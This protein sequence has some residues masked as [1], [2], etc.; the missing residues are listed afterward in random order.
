M[1]TLST[2][3]LPRATAGLSALAVLVGGATA[4]AQVTYDVQVPYNLSGLSTALANPY[5]IAVAPDGTVFVADV[6]SA[7]KGRVIMISPSGTVGGNPGGTASL[8]ATVTTL[9][10]T[11]G[12]TSVTLKQPNAVAVDSAGHLYIADISTDKVY[13]VTAPETSPAATQ[14]TYPGAG[15]TALAT[16]SANNLYVADTGNAIYKIAGGV[17]TALSISPAN[18]KPVGLAVD[19]SGNI[20]FADAR[21][22]ALYKYTAAGGTTTYLA[23]PSSGTFHFSAATAGLPIGMGFD[24]AGNL[25]VLDSEAALLWQI[26]SAT[27]TTNYEVPFSSSTTDPGSLAVS[28]IGNLYISDDSATTA[29]AELFYNNN[30]VNLGTINAGT[31]SPLLNANFQ[32]Q[33]KDSPLQQYENVEGDSTGEITI[34]SKSGKCTGVVGICNMRVEANYLAAAPGLRNGVIGFIDSGNNILAVHVIGTS[35]AAS[36]ALYP[37]IQNTLSQAT[38][39]LWQ[40]QA[41]A[42]TGDAQTFFVADQGADFS[43]TPPGYLHPAVYAYTV[44]AG[45][46]A[47]TPAKVGSFTAPTGLALDAFGNLY[48]ADYSGYVS[49]IPPTYNNG[50][51]TWTSSGTRLTFPAGITLNYPTSVAVDIY[52]NLYIADG[53]PLGVYA[54]TSNPGYI[55]KVPGNGGPATKLS[56]VIDGIPVI[57]P[58][59]LTTDSFGN[60]YIADGGDGITYNGS[61]DMVPIATGT[62]TAISFGNFA[63]ING[64][65]AVAFDAANDL[66]VVDSYNQRVLVVP[67]TYAG[68]VPT[69]DTAGIAPLGG[70]PGVSGL[71]STLFNPSSIV[72]WPGQNT[73]S[74]GDIGFQAPTGSSPYP[75]QVLTLQSFT[76][77]VNASSG[78][79]SVTGINVGNTEIKFLL[80]GETGSV[81]NISLSGCGTLFTTVEPGLTSACTSTITDKQGTGQ[82]TFTLNGS[83]AF[84]YS[85]LGNQIVVNAPSNVPPSGTACNGTYSGIFQGN[86]TVSAGQNCTFVNGGVTGN[87]TENGGNLTLTQSQVGGNV[88]I[89]GGT[90]TIGPGST[91][92]GNLQI[93]N[94]P[95]GAGPN[96]VCGTT[97][98]GNLQFQDSG[99]A[100]LIGSTNPASC[101]GNNVGGDLQVQNNTAA[102]TVAGNTVGGNLQDQNNTAPT[103]VFTNRVGNNLQCG[104]DTSITGGGNTAAS[105]QGQC[106]TF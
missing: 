24:P 37:G 91:V 11:V 79:A 3:S 29:V 1:F 5:G 86:I 73:V 59:D 98:N 19:A 50:V 35:L 84:D 100:L 55:I 25:Y 9:V 17:A 102:T 28:N 20:I 12:G 42:V 56:Y 78:S 6:E 93:Q 2:R 81:A 51:T 49:K 63:P 74:V 4:S 85:A 45:L 38:T 101:A 87:V 43:A 75:T 58:E 10:P 88:Q 66:Y 53:G 41:L 13:E 47:G 46:P 31:N 80:P 16:D 14:L 52:N 99:T 54:T 36:L 64:P 8:T 44:S 94:L 48:V 82:A 60:L 96:Q 106:S 57:Y 23:S 72:V 61:V 40:P 69:A 39:K 90:F 77:L 67:F 97:V 18:L 71:T 65:G 32:F 68:T 21:N 15:P 22:N 76:S 34:K 30:P 33:S 104:G 27:P 26:N 95:T 7:S 92:G 89:M 103:Q 83:P 70:L 62:A 105:K